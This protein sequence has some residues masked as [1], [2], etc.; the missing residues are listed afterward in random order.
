MDDP[1]FTLTDQHGNLVS[2]DDFD[3]QHL[4]VFFYPKAMTPG[5]TT[6]ACDFRERYDQ[7][8]A[9]GYAVVGVSP[10]PPDAN[11][12]FAEANDLSFPLLSDPD[13][14]VAGR[15][16]AWGTKRNYGREQNYR[17]SF[18]GS[19]EGEE[20][21]VAIAWK[22]G[23]RYLNPR[24]FQ[25]FSAGPDGIFNTSDDV[26]NFG[27]ILR[28]GLAEFDRLYDTYRNVLREAGELAYDR[29]GR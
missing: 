20:E 15:Y 10:D 3:G 22:D 28:K 2:R 7:F 25:V 17:M 27:P 8:L 24:T 16:G 13:H 12:R 19:P 21:Q 9:A 4:I 23:T 6:E 18:E 14:A 29:R 1:S 26:G 5:C 11:A